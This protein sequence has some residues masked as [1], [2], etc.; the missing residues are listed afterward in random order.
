MIAVLSFS[1][2]LPAASD[3]LT[4]CLTSSHA[5]WVLGSWW[6]A[7]F[8]AGPRNGSLCRLAQDV[9][10]IS[11]PM[12]CQLYRPAGNTYMQDSSATPHDSKSAN[13]LCSW[14]SAGLRYSCGR[15]SSNSLTICLTG[16]SAGWML[17]NTEA[18]SSSLGSWCSIPICTGHNTVNMPG[19]IAWGCVAGLRGPVMCFYHARCNVWH[20]MQQSPEVYGQYCIAAALMP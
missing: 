7:A 16:S 14:L 1:P 11:S 12:P 20:L 15:T 10:F 3:A 6:G 2:H 18:E 4:F 8:L 17:S 5:G 13:Q 9:G 19:C